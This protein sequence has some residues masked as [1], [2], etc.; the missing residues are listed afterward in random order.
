M[1]NNPP[2]PADKQIAQLL[3]TGRIFACYLSKRG[4]KKSASYCCPQTLGHFFNCFGIVL[5][6]SVCSKFRLCIC[7]QTCKNESRNAISPTRAN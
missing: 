4:T 6:F 1:N 7:A 2:L 5:L 3:L